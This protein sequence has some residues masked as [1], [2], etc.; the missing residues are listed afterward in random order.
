MEITKIQVAKLIKKREKNTLVNHLWNCLS[1][2]FRA[3]GEITRQQITFWEQ[4]I[5][6]SI[7]YPVFLFEF[8]GENKLIRITD[9]LNPIGKTI[10]IIV[11]LTFFCFFIPESL[12][13]LY[14]IN[15][16]SISLAAI[17]VGFAVLLARKIYKVEK[18]NQLE[19]IFEILKLEIPTRKYEEEWS[20]KNILIRIFTYPFCLFILVIC[21]WNLF[22]NG[23]RSI[24]FNF[25]G[26]G[27]CS[28]YLYFDIKMILREKRT[29]ANSK[30]K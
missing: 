22:E 28:M 6:I 26:I 16:V 27:F 29:T 12:C 21:M 2:D 8:N 11:L 24:L 1:R 4:D 10:T 5:W 23:F 9:A 15:W 18:Q 17:F 20:L 14:S 7:F 30:H 25:G 13:D 19:Q 3:K